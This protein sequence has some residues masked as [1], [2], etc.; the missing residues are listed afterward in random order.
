MRYECA[1]CSFSTSKP[2]PDERAGGVDVRLRDPGQVLLARRA[3]HLQRQ[4]A[5]HPAGRDSAALPL[6][7]PLATGPACPTW[8]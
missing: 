4:R 2:A 8:P 1:M 5:R 7:R 6:E 3:D